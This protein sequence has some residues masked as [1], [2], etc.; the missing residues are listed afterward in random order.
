[1]LRIDS[2]SN[3]HLVQQPANATATATAPAL[4]TSTSASC[5]AIVSNLHLSSPPY[6]NYFY[7]DCN[8]ASQVVVTSPQPDSNLTI[9]GPRLLIAWPAG[10]SGVVSFFQPTNGVN[11]T[12][13]IALMNS[14]EGSPL[15]PY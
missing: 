10:N 1:M 5:P 3:G 4:S 11:G 13:S 15:G 12:L 6:E 14:T 9:I 8:G 7:S 2:C